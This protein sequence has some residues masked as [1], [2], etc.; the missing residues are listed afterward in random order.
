MDSELVEV[1]DLAEEKIAEG[2]KPWKRCSPKT[3]TSPA[4]RE[5][6]TSS[7]AARQEMLEEMSPDSS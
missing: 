2:V 3:M 1:K 4:A 7:Q 5:G 6:S